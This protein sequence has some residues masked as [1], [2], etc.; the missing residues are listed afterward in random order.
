ME[1]EMARMKR[2]IVTMAIVLALG[3]VG[4]GCTESSAPPP[5]EAGKKSMEEM[6][7]KMMKMRPKDKGEAA[8]P[9]GESQKEKE[10]DKEKDKDKEKN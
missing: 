3:L 10:K 4:I 5:K 7:D 8:G 9:A 6:K 2:A 1:V